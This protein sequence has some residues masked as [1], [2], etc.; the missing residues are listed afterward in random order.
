LAL[1]FVALAVVASVGFRLL[2]AMRQIDALASTS[3]AGATTSAVSAAPRAE[4]VPAGVPGARVVVESTAPTAEPLVPES[5][6]TLRFDAEAAVR[7]AGDRDANVAELLD[8]PDP[9]V[10]GAVRD[11]ITHLDPPGGH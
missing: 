3:A 2:G 6:P 5:E 4:P 7:E 8:D 1:V 10:S 9:A 11:F